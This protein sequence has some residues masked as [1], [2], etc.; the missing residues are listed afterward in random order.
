MFGFNAGFGDDFLNSAPAEL[1][2][3]PTEP[4]FLRGGLLRLAS[5]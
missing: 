4:F 2:T 1:K 3:L 5:T